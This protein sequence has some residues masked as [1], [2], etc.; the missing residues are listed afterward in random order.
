MDID[1]EKIKSEIVEANETYRVGRPVMDDLSYD[2]LLEGY[3]GLVSAD[4]YSAFVRT[5]HE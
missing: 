4:E 3:K 5:L 2:K 1:I